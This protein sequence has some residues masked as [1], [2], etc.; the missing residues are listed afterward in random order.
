MKNFLLATAAAGTLAF[1]AVQLA[2]SAQTQTATPSSAVTMDAQRGVLT[3]APLLERATPAV[4]NIATSGTRST[5][6]SGDMEDMEDMM[7]RFFGDNFRMPDRNS[8]RGD[9]RTSSVGSGVIVDAREGLIMTNAHVVR[10]ADE[11]QVTLTDRRIL[12]A[13]IVGTDPATDIAILKVEARGLS[14]L[15]FADSEDIRVGDY[16]IAI[17]NPFGLGQ[18]VTSGIVSALGRTSGTTEYADFIQTDASINPGNSGGALINSKG[19]LVGINTAIISR[20]GGNNGIGFAVPANMAEGVMR[21]LVEYGEVRRGRIGVMIADVTP[22]LQEAYDLSVNR[23][24][25]VQSVSED[26]PAEKAGLEAGDVI[27]GF[28]GEE[29]VSGGDIR[30]TVGL[31]EAGTRTDITYLRD[32]KRRTTQI[33]VEA[34]PDDEEPSLAE[35]VTRRS[36]ADMDE[37]EFAGATVTDIPSDVDVRGGS[38]GVYVAR[39]DRNS[40]AARGG[41]RRGDIIRRV[42]RRDVEDLDEFAELV[43]RRRGAT[44]VEVER[45]GQNLFLAIR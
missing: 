20:S 3:M 36:S 10:G 28:N 8:P 24:A 38:E 30:N 41:L 2:P 11:V 29:I 7:R 37:E 35:R 44:A 31:V 12:D 4:V 9:N 26:T 16:V 15:D 45:D 40:R 34:A 42:D 13:E 14:E 1:G 22:T 5:N 27:V 6:G 19:E 32:G 43:E 18:T 17:G 25:L 23:G 39:V 21:Q 33:T